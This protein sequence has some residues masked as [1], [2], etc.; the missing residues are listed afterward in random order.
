MTGGRL[1]RLLPALTLILVACNPIGPGASPPGSP[2]SS[3]P[4]VG[5]GSGTAAL[6]RVSGLKHPVA[7]AVGEGSLWVTEYEQGNLVRIDPATGRVVARVHVGPHAS[8]VVVQEGF[9]WVLDDLASKI[10]PVDVVT[11]RVVKDIL[12][13]QSEDL[14]P[15]DLAG[16]AGSLWVTLASKFRTVRMPITGELLRFDTAT[17][18]LTV[19]PLGGVADGVAVGGGAVWVASSLLTQTSIF[20][21]DPATSRTVAKV[22]TGH[23]MSG[24]LAYADSG[25]WVANNDG[26]LTQ[27]DWRTNKVVGNFEVG[28]PQWAALVA[29]SQSIWISAPLD[30]LLAR[31]DPG[32]GAVTRAIRTGGRPQ[33]F[34]FLGNDIWVANYVD[35]TIVK[36]PIN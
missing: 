25:L 22:D 31:F 7:V 5:L 28:S 15:T 36:L 16:S 18:T 19:A 11:N 26:Y 27:I 23:P 1:R 3:S 4:A 12:L 29:Q 35:G 32:T 10:V 9:A 6:T 13:G 2:P 14:R 24:P 30:D 17:S 33:G 34:A 8:R 20:R 21:I